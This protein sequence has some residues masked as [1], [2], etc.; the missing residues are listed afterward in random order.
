MDGR[1]KE[2]KNGSSIP[3]RALLKAVAGAAGFAMGAPFVNPGR[4]TLHARGRDA[5]RTRA[6]QEYSARCIDLVTGSLVID[7]LSPLAISR[8]VQERWGPGLWGMT[9]Q[10][11]QDFR[12]SEIDVFHIG[13]GVGGRDFDDQYHNTLLFVSR[14]NSIIAER[15]DLFVR[16]DSVS[17]LASVHGSGRAGILIGTQTSSHFRGPDDVN[18]FH[19]LGQRVSQL[20]Y[21]SRNMIGNGSTERI[22]GGISDFGVAIV[23]RMT[24]EAIRAMAATGGVM[25]ITGVRMFVKDREPTTIEDYIDHFDHVRDLIGVEH[26]GVGSD[27]DLWGYDDMPADE[28]ESLKSGYKE[29][30]AFREKI[31]I[32]G[33]DHPKRMFDLTEAL[34][35]RGYTDEHIRGILGENFQRALGEI[36][37]V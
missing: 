24:D 32:E 14:Y 3:P 5:G 7:M 1:V 12:D 21:N 4:F 13:V 25:G 36:W 6:G 19:A 34:I 26:L 23:E 11:E 17:D 10:E 33:V 29:S 8:S 30:Y 20:T 16:V 2:G 22:D 15:P 9:E 31:D 18:A 28:Y 37:M 35:R 27:I